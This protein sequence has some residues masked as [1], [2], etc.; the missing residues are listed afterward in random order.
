MTEAQEPLPR[1]WRAYALCNFI[2]QIG[3]W[4]QTTAQAWL[5]LDLTGSP[6]RLGLLVAVQFLPAVFLAVAAGMAADRL[7]RRNLLLGAQA[8]MAVLAASLAAVAGSGLASYQLLLCFALL[9]G[10]GNAL[11]QPAR[12]SLAAALAGEEGAGAG[13]R[14]RAA[15]LASLSFNLAR[16][17]GPALAGFAIG[18]GG[19]FVAFGLNALSFAPLLLFLAIYRESGA[20]HSRK[21][22]SAR[23][24]LRFLWAGL[25]TRIPL[26]AVA[27]VGV[28]AINVQTLVPAYAR[29]SLGLEPSGFGML[30]GAV[31]VGA[32]FGG[33]LQWRWPAAS[34]W[35]SLAAAAGLGL[36]LAALSGTHLFLPAALILT[37]FGV[38][39]ATLLSSAAAAVQRAI[40]DHMRNAAAAI[41]VTIALG[42]NP[43]GSALTGWSL[44]RFGADA[45]LAALGAATLV[46]AAGLAL[47]GGLVSRA[48]EKGLD[49]DPVVV[50]DP[51]A[52]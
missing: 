52:K 13:G 14:M 26:L 25:A 44:E 4:M 7:G 3:T 36:C 47:F 27:A 40:P 34:I 42:T 43:L 6:E 28:L 39:S 11:S 31:G 10:L 17:L 38:C 21:R 33:A 5:V 1:T 8:A 37:V 51:A 23:E 50:S 29:L 24:A 20:A 48:G 35:R 19:P 16:I 32:C 18:A 46:A 12:I 22:G 2:S 41:Q 9:L 30:I 15:G 49:L 45:T